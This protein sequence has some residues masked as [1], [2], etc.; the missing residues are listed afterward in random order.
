MKRLGRFLELLVG[1]WQPSPA[2]AI[3]RLGLG[4]VCPGLILAYAVSCIIDRQ[5]LILARGGLTHVQGLPAVA[6]GTAYACLAAF[7]YVHVCWDDHP[8]LAGFRDFARQLLLLAIFIL[9]AGTLALA[10]I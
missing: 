3:A 9:M 6:V 7:L 8:H 4:V 10:L 5:A 2:V 1:R